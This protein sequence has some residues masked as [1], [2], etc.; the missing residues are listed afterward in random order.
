MARNVF[1]QLPDNLRDPCTSWWIRSAWAQVARVTPGRGYVNSPLAWNVECI[2]LIDSRFTVYIVHHAMSCEE[3]TI[4]LVSLFQPQQQPDIRWR[5]ES[6]WRCF[7]CERNP[8]TAQVSFCVYP[9]A[10]YSECRYFKVGWVLSLRNFTLQKKQW[11]WAASYTLHHMSMHATLEDIETQLF[12]NTEVSPILCWR[13][14]TYIYKDH[15]MCIVSIACRAQGT[16]GAY[17]EFVIL[18]WR[19]NP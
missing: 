8:Q 18:P 3:C 15:E 10:I 1:A 7:E 6:T 11:P 9:L 2:T 4:A 13:W 19:T 16:T 12:M 14:K 17:T 5:S